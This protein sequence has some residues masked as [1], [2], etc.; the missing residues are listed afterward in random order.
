MVNPIPSSC[1]V[2]V[3]G[4][5]PAGSYA[6]SALARE[7]VDV[8]VLES[9]VFPRYHI[10]ES[11]LAS[12]RYF[13]RF[14]DLEK[15]FDSYGFQK[16]LGAAFKFNDKPTVYTDFVAANG[17]NGYAW[18]VVRSEADELIFRH[19]EKSGAH[20][21]DGVR[22]DSIEFDH[23]ETDSANE[24]KENKPGRPVSASYKR[25]DGSTGSIKFDYVV[26]ASGRAGVMSTK[27]L[28]NRTFNEGLK[29]I[30]VWG[31]WKG[32][33]RYAVGTDRENQPFFEAMSDGSGW[34]WT[35][36]L[37]NGTMSVGVVMRKDLFFAKKKEA[38]SLPNY[39]SECIKLSPSIGTMLERAELVSDVKQATDW[40]YHASTYAGPN[41]RLAGDAGCFIDPFFSSGVH[42]AFA[43]GLSAAMTI[44]AARRGDCSELAAAKWHTTKVT[45]GY[46]RFLLVVVTSL[47]QIRKQNEPV[48]NDFDGEGFDRAFGFL[49]PIIQGTADADIG[50]K[51]TQDQVSKTIEFCLDARRMGDAEEEQAVLEKADKIKDVEKLTDNERKVLYAIRARREMRPNILNINSFSQEVIDGLT[52]RLEHT[53]LGLEKSSSAIQEKSFE[54]TWL[55]KDRAAQ[56]T[57]AGVQ[58]TAIE[59]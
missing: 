28:K 54:A 3:I 12:I 27:Y 23:D 2:L 36:P 24:E 47:K 38:E 20:V 29:N 37:H 22:V 5:G 19:A 49:R 7:G 31:Y 25:K 42:L 41:F 40:S 9:D 46:T 13:L 26:D 45:E 58:Q 43:S 44:Q 21:F 4:G 56:D 30:A 33:A 6:A 57:H 32:N 55:G 53:N 51:M 50:G 14:I 18:N 52:P 8:V 34:C 35:I 15:T 11:M 17:P 59:A 48:L 16:K 1:T 10:G 39:Y